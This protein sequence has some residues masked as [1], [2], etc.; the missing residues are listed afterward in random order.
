MYSEPGHGATFKVYLPKIAEEPSNVVP[1][2]PAVSA[3]TSSATILV[4]EDEDALAQMV[5][6]VLE[7]SG[8]AVL[9]AR[10]G[11]EALRVARNYEGTIDLM[12][13]D[14]ILKGTIDGLE[15][16]KR[17]SKVRPD[18]KLLFMSGYSDAL[19]RAGSDT[20]TKLL[21]KPF[22]NAELRKAVQEA[23]DGMATH[24]HPAPLS[25][26]RANFDVDAAAA[27]PFGLP[28]KSRPR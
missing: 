27:L 13:S 5:C 12:L 14:V 7:N 17:L 2:A 11:E 19:N 6:A 3:K 18:T 28:E 8:H 26:G 24:E 1:I 21:E 22:T 25:R 10:C 16:A 9:L 23:L 4:A 15:L 20:Q